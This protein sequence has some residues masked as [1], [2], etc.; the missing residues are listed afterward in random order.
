MNEVHHLKAES[1][2]SH[3]E[4]SSPTLSV[5]EI[6]EKIELTDKVSDAEKSQIL[7]WFKERFEEVRDSVD[8]AGE[9]IKVIQNDLSEVLSSDA[10]QWLIEFLSNLM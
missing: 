5:S 9:I 6:V 8:N 10:L 7:R 2:E 4:V 3:A 1:I